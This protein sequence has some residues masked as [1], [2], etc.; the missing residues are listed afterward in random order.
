MAR[1]LDYI[2]ARGW[3]WGIVTNKPGWLTRPLLAAMAL[4]RRIDCL[5][6]GDMVAHPKPDPEPL[7][8][9]CGQLDCPP[10]QALYIGDARRDIEAGRAAGLH[11][12][13]A[14]YG[15]IAGDEDPTGWQADAIVTTV[16]GIRDWLDKHVMA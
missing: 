9:A 4:D 7:Q 10:A 2:E 11:T 3:R 16:S 6:C 13:V 15:Y 1:L 5:V 8:V 12:L 14:G